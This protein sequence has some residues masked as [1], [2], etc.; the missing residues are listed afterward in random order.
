MTTELA[1]VPDTYSPS[2]D[3]DG[4]YV[5]RVPSFHT[6]ALMNGLRCSCGTR[7][8]KIY[9]SA[10]MFTAH[11]KT[12]KHGEWLKNL[13]ANKINYY[14]ENKQLRDLAQ[15]QKI[16]IV[17]MQV[18]MANKDRIIDNLTNGPIII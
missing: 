10:A 5:D 1:T 9:T 16:M 18:E 8:D 14:I 6:A 7:K 15:S 12:Q 4:N 17:K 11:I 2:M 13:N 3:E